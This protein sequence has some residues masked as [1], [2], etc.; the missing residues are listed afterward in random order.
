MITVRSIKSVL[1]GLILLAGSLPFCLPAAAG[2]ERPLLGLQAV[3]DPLPWLVRARRYP[4]FDRSIRDLKP[5]QTVAVT[6]RG[7]PPMESPIHVRLSRFA[8]PAEDGHLDAI[9]RFD[10]DLDEQPPGQPSVPFRLDERLPR[11]LAHTPE[12]WYDPGD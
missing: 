2:V 8:Y 10:L 7:R 9:V 1:A 3:T 11:A 12:R 5:D 6:S 4:A